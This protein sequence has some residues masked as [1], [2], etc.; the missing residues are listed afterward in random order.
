MAMVPEMLVSHGQS[1]G[2]ENVRSKYRA[3]ELSLT[4]VAVGPVSAATLASVYSIT[5]LGSSALP[6][7]FNLEKELGAQQLL[8]FTTKQ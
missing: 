4:V 7:R 2:L 1:S 6:Q 8:T 5:S 3:R